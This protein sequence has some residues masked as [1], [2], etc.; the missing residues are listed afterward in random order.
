MNRFISKS[1]YF[2]TFLFPVI[3]GIYINDVPG[4][5]I[6]VRDIPGFDITFDGQTT[7][8]NAVV[9]KTIDLRAIPGQN[10]TFIET[11]NVGNSLLLSEILK[12]LDSVSEKFIWS[13]NTDF[14]K[15]NLD[16]IALSILVGCQLVGIVVIATYKCYAKC[17][18]YKYHAARVIK[19]TDESDESDGDIEDI[20]E[21]SV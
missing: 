10:N 16:D 5:T 20:L 21:T 3:R 17:Y 14:K 9:D 7:V 18:I 15:T 19:T 8:E 4:E 11:A 12:E 2:F 6:D 13:N 1:V